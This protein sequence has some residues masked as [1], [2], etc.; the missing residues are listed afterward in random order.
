MAI[1]AIYKLPT[2]AAE[3]GLEQANEMIESATPTVCRNIIEVEQRAMQI[4]SLL[5]ENDPLVSELRGTIFEEREA[6][7]THCLFSEH[8]EAPPLAIL[9]IKELGL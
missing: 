7:A 9:P 6:G 2:S 1:I 3:V 4:L 8:N 5:L